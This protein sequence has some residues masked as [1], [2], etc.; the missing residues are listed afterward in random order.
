M[1]YDFIHFFMINSPIYNTTTEKMLTENTGYSHLFVY[2]FQDYM[3]TNSKNAIYDNTIDQINRI[4]Y[5]LN[6]GK[7][8]VI[9]ALEYSKQ[10]IAQ[11]DKTT[12]QKLIWCVWGHDIY[13]MNKNKYQQIIYN[14]L[15]FLY[16][17]TV[18]RKIH[19]AY[20]NNIKCFKGIFIGFSA[21]KQQLHKL[22]GKSLNIYH[23]QYPIGQSKPVISSTN[24]SK[25]QQTKIQVLLGHSAAPFLNHKKC[26]KLLTKFKHNIDIHIPMTYGC[27]GNKYVNYIERL[28]YKLFDK[29]NVHI[30]KKH[31][32]SEEYSTLLSNIDIAIFDNKYQAALGNI[33]LILYLNKKLFLNKHGVI[34]KGLQQDNVEIYDVNTIPKLTVENLSKQKSSH[35]IIYANDR[36]DTIKLSK[37]WNSAFK[38]I[39]LQ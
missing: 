32:S 16:N 4:K 14:G 1:K 36:L 24:S 26:L 37:Q 13:R 15:S 18:N 22:F 21:D 8:V 23:A 5:Y 17:H 35:N 10:S 7:Y 11:L 19:T 39:I 12:C 29:N 20:K 25:N 30:Y 34:Y 28:S 27:G 6:I 31:M 33:F 9:H 38:E 3:D 2:R